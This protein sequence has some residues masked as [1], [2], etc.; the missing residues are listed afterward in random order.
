MLRRDPYAFR[1]PAA[2][3]VADDA[4]GLAVSVARRDIEQVDPGSI[5]SHNVATASS[6]DVVPHGWPSPPPPSVSE[7]TGHS[8]PSRLICTA[9]ASREGLAALSDLQPV[10]V[11]VL[12]LRDVPPGEL[13]HV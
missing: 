7:L 4:L 3:R 9:G 8:S 6:R 1:Q 2:E 5:A 13:E 11:G 10:A 12:E